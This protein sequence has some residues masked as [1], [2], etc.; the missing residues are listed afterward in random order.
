MI[1]EEGDASGRRPS[2]RE[3]EWIRN[4]H[5]G[6]L[7]EEP[8]P[9]QGLRATGRPADR[10]QERDDHPDRPRAAA[11]RQGAARSRTSARATRVD[12]EHAEPDG[13]LLLRPAPRRHRRRDR[14]QR[15]RQDHALPHD[16]RPGAARRRHDRAGAQRAC[17]PTSTSTATPWTTTTRCSRR[18]PTARTASSWATCR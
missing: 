1:G 16:R 5:Q 15:H 6:R 13:G 11:G 18:S 17:F 8:G 12:G 3:L 14:S 10:R 2:Q 9:H 4:S 7:A